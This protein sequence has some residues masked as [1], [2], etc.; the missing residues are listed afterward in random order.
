MATTILTMVPILESIFLW[1]A[2]EV[3]FTQNEKEN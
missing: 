2:H 1:K 3:E